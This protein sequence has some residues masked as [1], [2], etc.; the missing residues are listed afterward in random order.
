M[1]SGTVE[2]AET[3]K[4]ILK[5]IDEGIHVVDANGMTIFY[6]SVAASLDGLSPD[7]VHN[8]HVLDAFPS[9]TKETSTLLKV[10][11]SGIPIHN[12]HQSYRNRKGIQIDTVNSTLPLWLDG[13]LI[14]AVEIAKDISKI[15]Q[16]SDQLLDL[17]AKIKSQ[18]K[19]KNK[20]EL[21]F[22]TFSDILSK[23][24]L[25][26]ELKKQSEKASKTNSPVM[27]Y[28]ETGTGKEMFVQA[29]HNASNRVNKPFI[30]QNCAAIP[31]PLLESIFFGTTKGSFTGAVDRPGVFELADGG[32][33][34]LDE[35]NSMPIELQAKILRVV[36][37][38]IVQRIGSGIARKVD[39]RIISALNE[40]PESCLSR[41]VLRHD[42]FYRL[43]VV[44]LELP[45]LRNR[46]EDIMYLIQYFIQKYNKEFHKK[47]SGLSYEAENAVC[48]YEWP[49]NI[50]EL[51]H[52]IEHA[53]N[54]VDEHGAI[55]MHLLPKHVKPA[56]VI[57]GKNFEQ[58]DIPP[59]KHALVKLEKQLIDQALKQTS[60]NIQQAARLLQVPR[61]TLQYKLKQK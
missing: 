8:Y 11:Q 52:A 33:L 18:A 57:Q 7:E 17:Q 19:K 45:P 48:N 40:K 24:S 56:E 20:Q 39:V 54:F 61:Q 26:N 22:Y 34:F 59:L 46:G 49:G 14:G 58:A 23:N 29:I 38:G 9:L 32:T 27:I 36:Q 35:I 21:A 31:G 47:I 4:A 30:V 15:K 41:G 37:E 55:E 43:N 12:Q 1:I 6:N 50:R 3:L 53:M 5:T 16:L 13:E 25:I 42:L 28:G 10:I 60:G 2:T 44:S 51:K